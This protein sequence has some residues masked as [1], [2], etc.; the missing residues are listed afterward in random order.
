MNILAVDTSTQTMNIALIGEKFKTSVRYEGKLEHSENLVPRILELLKN[1]NLKLK[2]LDLLVCTG[3]PGSF[4]G[5][6][7]AMSALK[8]VSLG[9]ETPLVTVETNRV[10]SSQVSYFDGLVIPVI[11]AKKRRFYSAIF[12]DGKRLTKD[13]DC[14]EEEIIEILTGETRVLLTGPDAKKFYDKLIAADISKKLPDLK[15]FV[16]EGIHDFGLA[17]AIL[18]LKQFEENGPSE[19][20]IG[21]T[22]I[23][24]SDAEVALEEKIKSLQK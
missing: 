11:D 5:L 10:L 18:G 19:L 8:G 16:D 12:K 23:R 9:T 22:Y 20:G 7:I 3:G 2:D 6:R 24:K 21:P 1:H 15:I 17:L 13:M 4:T 14:N